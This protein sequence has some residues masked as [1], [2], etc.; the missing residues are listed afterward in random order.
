MTVC[1]FTWCWG[2]FAAKI[3][4]GARWCFQGTFWG[5][6]LE[7]R[8]PRQSDFLGLFVKSMKQLYVHQ[9]CCFSALARLQLCV[10]R[11]CFRACVGSSTTLSQILNS[12]RISTK[13]LQYFSHLKRV[14]P[15]KVRCSTGADVHDSIGPFCAALS[16]QK[17]T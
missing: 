2:P 11:G 5:T 4:F 10:R 9:G 13:C 17:F 12:I 7:N 16:Q 14:G 3:Q 15:R 6:W 1:L 8:F